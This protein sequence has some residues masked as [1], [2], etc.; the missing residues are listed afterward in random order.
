MDEFVLAN[1]IGIKSLLSY[2]KIV[3]N[4]IRV[5]ILLFSFLTGT[6]QPVLPM[7]EYHLFKDYIT[8]NLCEERSLEVS[9]C[10]GMCYLRNQIKDHEETR[11]EMPAMTAEYYP[12]TILCDGVKEITLIPEDRQLFAG[13]PQTVPDHLSKVDTPPPEGH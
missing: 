4:P 3:M 13:L 9:E 6:I 1:L 7:L 2:I 10:E 12:G 8:E 5:F 11:S